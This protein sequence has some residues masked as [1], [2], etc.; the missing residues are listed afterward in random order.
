MNNLELKSSDRVF[1]RFK[2]GVWLVN[3]EVIKRLKKFCKLIKDSDEIYRD[4]VSGKVNVKEISE[5]STI[6]VNIGDGREIHEID[7]KGNPIQVDLSRAIEKV[8]EIVKRENP[9]NVKVELIVHDHSGNL[10]IPSIEDIQAALSIKT[11]L[12]ELSGIPSENFGKFCVVRRS[13]NKLVGTCI[14]LSK[15]DNVTISQVRETLKELV[16]TMC[17]VARE[18]KV[19]VRV[20]LFV[21]PFLRDSEARKLEDSFV[22]KVK[23]LGFPIE[24]IELTCEV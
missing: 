16:N 9:R 8:M 24:K 11:V 7:V 12:Q 18:A 14:D 22:E 4:I 1:K 3:E 19:G 20:G 17:E 6:V 2:R 10:A 5:N 15:T 13:G 23:K 21:R